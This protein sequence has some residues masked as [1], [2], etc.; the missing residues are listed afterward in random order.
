MTPQQ[1][2]RL[3]IGVGLLLAVGV[4]ALSAGSG[5]YTLDATSGE[6]AVVQRFGR[7]VATVTEPGLHFKLPFG[8]DRVTKERVQ[9]V[10]RVTVGFRSDET[11]SLD[12]RRPRMRG[13]EAEHAVSITRDHNL[14]NV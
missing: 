4:V 6:A 11:P 7:Y 8:I 9:E 5:W 10:R 1:I 13:G 14:V 12:P 2:R 3:A